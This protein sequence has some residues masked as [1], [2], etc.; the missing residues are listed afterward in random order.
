[1]HSPFRSE[2]DVFRGALLVLAGA[3]I[4][5]LVGWLTDAAW[6]GLIA[7]LLVGLAAGLTIRAGRGS[8]PEALSV[9]DTGRDEVHRILVL[10]NQTVEG[11]DLMAA[12][13][14]H[15]SAYARTEVLVVS[16]SIPVTRLQL[17]TSDTDSA[18]HEAFERLERSLRTLRDAGYEVDGLRGDEDPLQAAAD[19]LHGFAADEVIVSTLPPGR[20]RWLERDIVGR[21]RERVSLPVTHVTSPLAAEPEGAAT[22][23]A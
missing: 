21:L 16:P 19:A 3:T 7:G 12:I 13:D 20:S 5:V 6:G 1:M 8:I 15:S 17:I 18:R 11:P 23:A 4:A 2:S 9:A 22:G 10:A 14:A